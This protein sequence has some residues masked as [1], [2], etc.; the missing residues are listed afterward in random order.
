MT[1]GE[2]GILTTNRLEYYEALQT[3]INCGRA[4][5]TDKFGQRLLGLNYRMTDLQMALL[6]GQ[7]ETLPELRARRAAHASLLTR[8][9]AGIPALA[10]GAEG[11]GS[12][13]ATGQLDETLRASAEILVP[14]ARVHGLPIA[15]LRFPAEIELSPNSGV[16]SIHARHWTGHLAGGAVRGDAW[17]RLGEDRSFRSDVQLTGLDLEILSR[18]QS[19]GKHSAS[20]KLSGSISLNG[21]NPNDLGKL[22]GRVDLD[23]DEA[24]LVE[25]PVFRE[26][27][28]FLEYGEALD[29]VVGEG[30]GV[31]AR[32]RK[33]AA[34]GG[35]IAIEQAAAAGG[36]VEP[37]VGVERERVGVLDA[38]EG[39]RNG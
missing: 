12:V 21:P 31:I 2:G 34:R 10:R 27:D 25:M 33:G 7:I 9:L 18:L 37:L 11:F 16:G 4:S 26:L 6:L 20:G 22:R 1:S 8:L 32:M 3:V 36:L 15:E 23:L 14:R 35:G 24:S 17:L 38:A 13:R 39:L 5:L 28:R 29:G 19:A 30:A